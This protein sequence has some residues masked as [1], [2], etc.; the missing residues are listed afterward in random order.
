MRRLLAV[1]LSCSVP[2]IAQVPAPTGVDFGVISVPTWPADSG[3]AI[4]VT[5][6]A[7]PGA[8][9]YHIR[10]VPAGTVIPAAPADVDTVL[11][12]CV[13]CWHQ[14][15]AYAA[16]RTVDTLLVRLKARDSLPVQAIVRALDA[17]GAP[18]PFGVSAVKSLTRCPCGAIPPPPVVSA[19]TTWATFVWRNGNYLK[20]R[21]TGEHPVLLI[22][23]E[24]RRLVWFDL[25]A[26]ARL[27]TLPMAVSAAAAWAQTAYV[28]EGIGDSLQVMG[29]GADGF[30]VSVLC[31]M[32][33]TG[34]TLTVK[35][36][37][38]WGATIT[39]T[40]GPL[41]VAEVTRIR[42]AM[43]KATGVISPLNAPGW[44]YIWAQP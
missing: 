9:A 4:R 12:S 42:Q 10:L 8:T 5:W 29:W 36:P 34:C 7:P 24:N 41:P 3:D 15:S 17:I 2:L 19:D 13:N 33:T 20:I 16:P 38:V 14:G 37:L 35:R 31:R 23:T 40:L 30:R 25:K 6:T 22:S 43:L 39:A 32:R 11:A 28:A 1:L 27:A 44:P 18:G 21:S 26:G